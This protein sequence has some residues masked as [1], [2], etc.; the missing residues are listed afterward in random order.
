[1]E[2]FLNDL[3]GRCRLQFT[4]SGD[5]WK[6][7]LPTRSTFSCVLQVGPD[8]LDWGASI[9]EAAI[10]KETYTDWNDYLGYDDRELADLVKDKQQDIAWFV[11]RWT[12]ASGVRVTVEKNMLG[13]FKRKSAEW[14]HLGFWSNVTLSALGSSSE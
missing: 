11:E 12:A 8:A 6:V 14:Q 7:E 4:R 2:V 3:A 9:S 10:G 1:M 5:G 13:F